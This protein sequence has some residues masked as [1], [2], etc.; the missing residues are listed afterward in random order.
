MG[1]QEATY[2]GVP[3]L[4]IP[5]F[6]DQELNLKKSQDQGLAIMVKYDDITEETLKNTLKE[7]LFTER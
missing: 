5:L 7:L 6:A 3:R 4:G 1:T 2:C